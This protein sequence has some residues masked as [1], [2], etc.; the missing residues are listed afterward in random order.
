MI[1]YPLQKLLRLR[2]VREDKAAA[3]VT[4]R[5]KRLAEAKMEKLRREQE[6]EKYI[7]WRIEKEKELFEEIKGKE[8]SQK[9]L[10]NYKHEVLKLR[11]RQV[12]MEEAILEAQKHIEQ[13]QKDLQ[14][15]RDNYLAAVRERKKI[16]EHRS[17]WLEIEK[18]RQE[19]EEEKE[20]EEFIPKKRSL[21]S[22]GMSREET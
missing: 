15:A 9:D 22:D 13:C 18:L 14:T 2:G 21:T 16:E 1:K 17:R 10:D 6:L 4:N 5:K 11:G 7:R 12:Q 20:L 8:V 19:R 3:E